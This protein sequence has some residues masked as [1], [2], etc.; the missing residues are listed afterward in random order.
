MQH[1]PQQK[2]LK[3]QQK[4]LQMQQHSQNQS[5]MQLQPQHKPLQQRITHQLEMQQIT[6]DTSIGVKER[7]KIQS[8]TAIGVQTTP[9]PSPTRLAITPT[10]V[11]MR[12]KLDLLQTTT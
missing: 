10:T 7:T 3:M 5:Q 12:S 11:S 8:S 2:L 9:M 6:S 4:L 1:Q